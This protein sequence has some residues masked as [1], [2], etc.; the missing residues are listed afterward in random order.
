MAEGVIVK[1]QKQK[2][3]I[4]TYCAYDFVHTS[5]TCLLALRTQEGDS[6]VQCWSKQGL[7]SLVVRNWNLF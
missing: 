6:S 1:C 5:Q 4:S 2:V 7:K 3:E